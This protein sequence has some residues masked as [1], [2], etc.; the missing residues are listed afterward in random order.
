MFGVSQ[1]H[2]PPRPPSITRP[3]GICGLLE[4]LGRIPRH[5]GNGGRLN[6]SVIR[7]R[8]RRGG[9]RGGAEQHDGGRVVLVNMAI[10]TNAPESLTV[11]VVRLSYVPDIVS[12]SF[13]CCQTV[14]AWFVYSFREVVHFL[15]VLLCQPSVWHPPPP[16]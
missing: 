10:E 9:Q 6:L 5:D 11:R 8:S 4:G 15:S 1:G 16:H 2:K 3:Y 12:Q 7:I 14:L 13:R